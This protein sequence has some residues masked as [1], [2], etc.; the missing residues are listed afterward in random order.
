MRIASG[1]E[2]KQI[3]VGGGAARNGFLLQFMADILDVQIIRPRVSESS[4]LGAAFLAGLATGFWESLTALQGLVKIDR[5]YYPQFSA[6]QRE[7]LY[8]SWQKA[9]QRSMNWLKE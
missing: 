8:H 1:I 9:V 3:H 7:H 4:V 2:I 5:V 6:D